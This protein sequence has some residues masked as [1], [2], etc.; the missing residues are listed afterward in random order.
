[1]NLQLINEILSKI[2]KTIE[3]AAVATVRS[4]SKTITTHT[5]KVEVKNPVKKV[6]VEGAVE[7]TNHPDI[8]PEIKK[9]V[10]AI[11]GLKKPLTPHKG[12]KVENFPKFPA[13]PQFPKEFKVS[14]LSNKTELSNINVIVN[15]LGELEKVVKKI[16]LDPTIKVEAPI[17]NL[18]APTVKVEKTPSPV[19][20]V[21]A[22]D[23]SEFKKIMKFLESLDA[24]NPLAVR[25]S[26]GVKFYKAVD[27]LA[28]AYVA[29][30]SAP[31]QDFG[32]NDARP[33]VNRNGELQVTVADTWDVNDVEKV[34]SA[35]T[36]FGEESVDGKWRVREVVRA[37]V[38]TTIRHATV[39]NNP[40]VDGYGNAWIDR[41]DLVYGYAREAL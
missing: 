19:V 29:N 12:V 11:E 22:P 39:R 5:Y 23:L 27:R 18:P 34:S 10:A 41:A 31:F 32:N 1:M 24:K 20:N 21:E 3:D 15:A 16:K 25:L 33:V 9:L 4:L 13:F 8:T 40:D 2:I 26:D 38:L 37:G 36:Y 6:G 17:V 14:N 7:V 35:L 28:E 30:N